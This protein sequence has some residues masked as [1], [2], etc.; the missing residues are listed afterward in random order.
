[1]FS[2]EKGLRSPCERP[3]SGV[4]D[5]NN[6]AA[7]AIIFCSTKRM[8]PSLEL[9]SRSWVAVRC[10]QLQRDLQ[11]NGVPCAA[12]H[13]DKGQRE[14]EHALGE[15]K[16]GAMKLIVATDV[17]ARGIDVKGVT[18]VVNYD[19]PGNTE[20]YVH[21]IGRTGR[22]GQKGYAVSLITEKDAHALRGIIEVMRRT[23][24]ERFHEISLRF[25]C[26]S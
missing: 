20:D 4:G 14:R 6:S 10:D 16:S 17:A 24:Q 23:N 15:L 7:K 22:A 25:T 19:A 2:A 18:L 13:G 1:M 9:H 5:R 26:F 21:R 8:P 3:G 11:R 12:I